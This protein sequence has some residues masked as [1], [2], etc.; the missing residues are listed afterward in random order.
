MNIRV[1]FLINHIFTNISP[2]IFAYFKQTFSISYQ[3]NRTV[4]GSAQST[5]NGVQKTYCLKITKKIMDYPISVF[6]LN[7]VDPEKDG[8]P[9]YLEKIKKPMDLNTV[10]SKLESNSYPS[11]DKWKE[12]MNLIWKNAMTYNTEGNY[13]HMIAKELN[14]VFRRFCETIP[15]SELEAWTFRVRKTHS[16]LMKLIESKPDPTRKQNVTAS[17][18]KSQRPTKILLRQK[19]T[20]NVPSVT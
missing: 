5:L 11:I 7:P 16:K 4:R 10:K 8:A 17:V 12:E 18:P 13:I 2:Y 20:N 15:K 14:E 3:M 19:S 6:F 9:D 1:C